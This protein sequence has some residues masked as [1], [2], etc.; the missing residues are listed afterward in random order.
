M[1]QSGIQTR[2]ADSIPRTSN[3]QVAR[4]SKKKED[5]NKIRLLLLYEYSVDIFSMSNIS[6]G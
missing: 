1:I 6:S 2:F 4:T 5:C 3:R